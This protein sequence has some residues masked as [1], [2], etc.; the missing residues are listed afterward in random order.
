MQ[1]TFIV[2][3]VVVS[4]LLILV[5]LIQTGKAGGIGG[6]FGGSGSEQLFSTPSGSVFLKKTTLV[7]AAAFLVTTIGLTLISYRTSVETVTSQMPQLPAPQQP[8]E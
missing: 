8:T 6:I 2:L 4:L 5:V 7:L 3:H 1:I